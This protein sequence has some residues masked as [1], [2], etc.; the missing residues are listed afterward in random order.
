MTKRLNSRRH[1]GGRRRASLAT[2]TAVVVASTLIA[3]F[4]IQAAAGSH[5][6]K[7]PSDPWAGL[8]DQQKQA[9]VDET[10]AKNVR[11]LEGFEA[12]HGDPRS[13]RVITVSTWQG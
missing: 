10:H 3:L 12:R 13:L 9:I 7:Q 8:S 4:A 5:P 2:S 6:G 11:F 1:D